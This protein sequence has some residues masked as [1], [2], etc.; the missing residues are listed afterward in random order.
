MAINARV[1]ICY[2]TMTITQGGRAA[3]N[4]R[5]RASAPAGSRPRAHL[6]HIHV[7]GEAWPSARRQHVNSF[8]PRPST[9]LL[10]AGA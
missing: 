7:C 8:S 6:I 10:T 4:S 5:L 1:G 9:R 3:I 2:V